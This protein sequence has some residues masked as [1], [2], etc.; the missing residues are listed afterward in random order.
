MLHEMFDKKLI[1][2]CTP[3]N[4][5]TRKTH[6]TFEKKP[7]TTFPLVKEKGGVA[8]KYLLR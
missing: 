6:M 8:A 1:V 3:N 7:T 2:K 5:D 4:F